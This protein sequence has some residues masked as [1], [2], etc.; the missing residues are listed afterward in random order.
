MYKYN[1]CRIFSIICFNS[2]III[3]MY[4]IMMLLIKMSCANCMYS[5]CIGNTDLI[6]PV[7]RPRGQKT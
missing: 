1:V 6:V 4:V 2:F 5:L 3:A 7:N